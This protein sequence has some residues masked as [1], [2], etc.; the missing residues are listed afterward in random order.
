MCNDK[1]T[2]IC[3]LQEFKWGCDFKQCVDFLL[4]LPVDWVTVL[5]E[6]LCNVECIVN[7]MLEMKCI[8]GSFF[9][10]VV[11]IHS[12]N[13]TFY[14]ACVWNSC[15]VKMR[16]KNYLN[17]IRLSRVIIKNKWSC[18]YGPPCRHV[19]LCTYSWRVFGFF[20]ILLMLLLFHV[21]LIWSAKTFQ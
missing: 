21:C 2:P 12:W 17:W 11:C 14:C 8:S 15:L 5:P 13:V 4:Q 6:N 20:T 9:L 16:C 10:S 7:I 3:V 19:R 18:F 1:Y